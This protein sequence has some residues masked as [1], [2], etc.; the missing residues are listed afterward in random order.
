MNRVK[1]L[2]QPYI[3][4]AAGQLLNLKLGVER[5]AQIAS[6]TVRISPNEA[7]EIQA[8]TNGQVNA[9]LLLQLNKDDLGSQEP[10]AEAAGSDSAKSNV[11]SAKSSSTSARGNPPPRRSW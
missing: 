11:A 9:D 10:V 3:G 7:E 6:G 8:A 1:K 2:L 4:T 5:A